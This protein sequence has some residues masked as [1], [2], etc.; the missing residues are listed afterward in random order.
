MLS[1]C[2]ILFLLFSVLTPSFGQVTCASGWVQYGENCYKIRP[3][4][5]NG[6]LGTWTE[7]YT[8][9]TTAY[10]NLGSTM[11]CINNAAENAWILALGQTVW[12]G[13][14]T[15]PPYGGGSGT[16]IFGWVTGCSSTYTN[17]EGGIPNNGDNNQHYAAMYGPYTWDEFPNNYDF[18]CGCQYKLANTSSPTTTPS[19]RPSVGDVS[20]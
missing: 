9:C 5:S 11:Y 4:F 15:M 20:E 7:C 13:Y 3:N 12:L 19:F 17:W 14:T 10:P 1:I 2:F 16:M 6:E 18:Y 8:H